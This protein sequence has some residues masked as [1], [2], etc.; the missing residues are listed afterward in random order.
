[1]L[2]ALFI[3]VVGLLGYRHFFGRNNMSFGDWRRAFSPAASE[4][5][6]EEDLRTGQQVDF[7][8]RFETPDTSFEDRFETPDT[9]SSKTGRGGDERS[10]AMIV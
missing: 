1:M 2:V 7:E 3:F 5:G 10:N 4:E 6:E 8:E 9:S